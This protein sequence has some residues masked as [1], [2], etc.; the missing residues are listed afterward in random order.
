MSTKQTCMSTI[1]DKYYDQLE[2]PRYP[3][4]LYFPTAMLLEVYQST[5]G[6]KASPTTPPPQTNGIGILDSESNGHTIPPVNIARK[7]AGFDIIRSRWIINPWSRSQQDKPTKLIIG[8][9]KSLDEAS[10]RAILEVYEY[11][12]ERA[13][14]G[15]DFS[16][17]PDPDWIRKAEATTDWPMTWKVE[18]G[19]VSFSLTTEKNGYKISEEIF[20]VR[21]NISNVAT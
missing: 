3:V 15:G 18:D 9:N 5:S 11:H 14:A 17:P 21:S 7:E 8:T 2:R 4:H 6:S 12:H 19:L 10:R 1:V 16:A 20:I 13:H